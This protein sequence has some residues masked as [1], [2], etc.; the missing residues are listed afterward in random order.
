[1][2]FT[3]RFSWGGGL[4]HRGGSTAALLALVVSTMLVLAVTARPARASHFFCLGFVATPGNLACHDNTYT[5]IVGVRARRG[6]Y[7]VCASARDVAGN[8]FGGWWCTSGGNNYVT[9]TYGGEYTLAGW[10]RSQEL[11]AGAENGIDG[12]TND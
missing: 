5:R 3:H 7:N 1:M 11:P 6:N 4:R 9:H 12:W 8:N 10:I 2:M